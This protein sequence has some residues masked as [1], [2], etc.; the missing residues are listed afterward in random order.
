LLPHDRDAIERLASELRVSPL[1]AQLLLNRGLRD[2][3]TARHFLEAP[4]T[5]LHAPRL[6]PDVVLAAERLYQAVKDGQRICI[7]GDYDVDGITGT[8]MLQQV[9]R[10]IGGQAVDFYV[11]HRLEEGYGLNVEALRQI[12][13]GGAKLVVTVD[14]GIASLAEAEEAQRLG[15]ELII[16]DH[17]EFKET[18]PSARVLVHPRL[19][20][21]DY[22]FGFLCGAGVAFKL[23]WALCQLASGGTEKVQDRFRSFLLDCVA[24]TALGTVAD[25]VPLHDENRVFVRY[26]LRQLHK[27]PSLGLKAL[28]QVSGLAEKKEL[29]A[30]D[31]SF[32]LAP[33][34][35]AASRLGCARLLLELL[36]T[37]SQERATTLARFLEDQ[38]QKR[39]QIER[40]MLIEARSQLNGRDLDST[41]AFVL[42]DPDWH[43]GVIGIVAG[44]L[45]DHY[46]RPTLLIALRSERGEAGVVGQGSGRSVPGFPL[47]EALHACGDHLLSHGGHHAAAGFKIDPAR[48]DAFREGFCAHARQ[49]FG[50]QLPSPRLV[51]DAEVSLGMLT[52]RQVEEL[53]RLEPYGIANRRPLFLT[54]SVQ[55]VGEPRKV[56]GGERHLRFQVRQ[57][58]AAL[59]VIA[60]GMSERAEELMSA[61]GACCLAFTP[62]VSEWQGRRSVK[63]EVVDF[64]AGT[65]AKIV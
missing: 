16:T 25:C 35:N 14:C 22:P 5:D 57:E 61:G 3:G 37:C 15:L 58:N 13:Q 38:N 39:Q 18:L 48:I 27:V 62:R 26:G 24:L 20:G 45:A 49:H 32:S 21:G 8:A 7:Y 41:P 40:R 55:V 30:D 9:L 56:G 2:G 33:R 64:Q 51:L 31:V 65:Q 12:A 19:P 4:L 53:D 44:R 28:L 46:A 36:T 1:V 23:A 54:G 29:R 6:L 50:E 17:H 47:H 10:L 52:V 60:F 59:W 43:P 34:L 42:A 11:P 63:L